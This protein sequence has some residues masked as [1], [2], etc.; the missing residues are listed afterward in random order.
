MNDGYL[1]ARRAEFPENTGQ[2][3]TNSLVR[4][5]NLQKMCALINFE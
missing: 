5:F 1:V 3:F 2:D 4:L